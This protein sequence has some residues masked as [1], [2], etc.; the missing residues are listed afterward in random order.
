MPLQHLPVESE[1][2]KH[3]P[4]Y[5][6]VLA[7]FPDAIVEI[8]KVSY[9][10]NAKHNPGEPLHWAR[11]KSTDHRD[12]TARHLLDLDGSDFIELPDGSCV[13]VLHAAECAWR[14]LAACQI[15]CELRNSAQSPTHRRVTRKRVRK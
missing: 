15:V 3:I 10:G 12:A 7:Y 5:S 13:E 9:V 8:A 4:I 6:G 14:A 11:D 1:D 2:R